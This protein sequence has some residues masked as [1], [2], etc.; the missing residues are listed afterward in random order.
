MH[1]SSADFFSIQNSPNQPSRM[2]SNPAAKPFGPVLL[3]TSIR[4]PSVEALLSSIYL[5]AEK[6]DHDVD[7]NG[8]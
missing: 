3:S 5:H 8:S 6:P 4:D 7:S 1:K 2:I